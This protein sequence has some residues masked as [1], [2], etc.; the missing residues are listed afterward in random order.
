MTRLDS[1][2][3]R[4]PLIEQRRHHRRTGAGT[5]GLHHHRV[6]ET[7]G[8]LRYR[9]SHQVAHALEGA[10]RQRVA[11]AAY[12]GEVTRHEIRS[13]RCDACGGFHLTSQTPGPRGRRAAHGEIPADDPVVE[14]STG[15]T[16]RRRI[17][18]MAVVA[19]AC[20]A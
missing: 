7:T 8:K 5:V 12:L 15:R 19:A 1:K 16:R 6:C 10:R 14:L 18:A 13:Y 11:E 4:L 3:L 9:D 20:A 17:T 2:E